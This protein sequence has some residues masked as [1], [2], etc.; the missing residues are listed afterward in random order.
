MVE[1][2]RMQMAGCRGEDSYTVRSGQ[3]LISEAP[4]PPDQAEMMLRQHDFLFDDTGSFY[5]S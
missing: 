2:E 4:E 5:T 1:C 3:T